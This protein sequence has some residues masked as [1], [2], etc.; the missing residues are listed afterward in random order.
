[1]YGSQEQWADHIA[2]NHSV[3]FVKSAGNSGTGD[4]LITSPGMAYNVI[5]VGAIDDGNTLNQG[6][7]I[8]ANYSS[9]Q[10]NSGTNKPDLVAPG[11]NIRTAAGQD[12][13]TSF[14]APHVT[15]T[16]AQLL[17]Q[18]P[19]L[20]TL[21]DG[22]KAILTASISHSNLAYA[23]GDGTN[24]NT[25]GAGVVDSRSSSWTISS[26]RYVT[27]SFAANSLNGSEKTYYFNVSSSD[28]RIRVSL[29][30][31]K[32]NSITGAHTGN[33]TTNGSLADLDLYV[34]DSNGNIVESAL[35]STNNVEIV[36]FTPSVTGQYM[37]KVRQYSNSD[38]K[39]Y[40]GLAWW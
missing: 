12:S 1:M 20:K 4:Q 16:I 28:T 18:S 37:I 5:T 23:T 6:N 22:M 26:N 38:Q 7:D 29:S 36:Q 27:S 2:I 21:Q 39:V 10:E 14:A 15:A 32:F 17:Q 8:I 34:Y 25:Y 33:V 40:F 13:G 9:F 35:S 3:H 11:S 19:A 24:F 30:W 31:L